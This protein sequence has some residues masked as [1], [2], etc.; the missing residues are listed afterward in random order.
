MP[1]K[2]L[3]PAAVPTLV[4]ERLHVWGRSIRAQRQRQRIPAA[5][6]AARM[7]VSRA[8]L[9]RVER[10]DPGAADAAPGDAPGGVAAG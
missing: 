5:D 4:Q 3:A 10:G 7:Q 9:Q 1:I 6:L 2:F 8:T